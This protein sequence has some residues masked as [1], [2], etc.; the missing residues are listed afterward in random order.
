MI[1]ILQTLLLLILS[2]VLYA[3]KEGHQFDSLLFKTLERNVAHPYS[4]NGATAG[5]NL[6]KLY[7]MGD[8]IIVKSVYTSDKKF[9]ALNY[10]HI[11]KAINGKY[12]RLIKS[13]YSLIIPIYFYY[14][15]VQISSEILKAVEEK[16]RKFAKRGNVISKK[17]VYITEFEIVR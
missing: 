9:D 6:L 10:E 5:V 1:R 7:K 2:Y 3:Q 4:T 13:P 14:S 17:P 12:N 16:I 11:S 8:S 15:D